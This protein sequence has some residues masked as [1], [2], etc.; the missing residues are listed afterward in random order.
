MKSL[1]KT[2][3]YLIELMT[4]AKSFKENPIIGST[5]LNRCGLHVVRLLLSHFIMNIRML[6]LSAGISAEDRKQ[7]FQQGYLV[8]EN[9]L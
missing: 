8:K 7:F 2:P 3:L 6:L 4:S 9:F 1:L 5:I